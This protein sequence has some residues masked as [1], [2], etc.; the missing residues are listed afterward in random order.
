MEKTFVGRQPI[1]RDGVQVFAYEL[2][3]RTNE[4]NEAAL[5]KADKATGESLV[6]EFMD[7]GLQQIAGQHPAFLNVTRDFVLSEFSSS[8]L[9][10]STVLQIA[11]DTPP[12]ADYVNALARLSGDGYS[13]ALKD[14]VYQ[15]DVRPL[16]EVADIVKLNVQAF[17]RV[18]LARQINALRPHKVKLLAEGVETHSD[19]QH[20]RE[21][22]F[23]Y[24]EGYFFCKPQHASFEDRPLPFNRMSMLQ[25]L[26][27]LQDPDVSFAELELAISRDVAMSYRILR[28]LNSP[29]NALPRKVESLRHAISLVGTNL[30]RQWASVI[31][32]ES[33]ED[34][35]R[36]L[37]IMAMIRA[38]MC[39]QL[40]AAMGCRNTE[41]FFTVG[42]LSLLDALLDRPMAVV[43]NDLP[44]AESIE[45]ALLRRNGVMGDALNC[46]QAYERCNWPKTTCGGLD[47]RKIR[48]TYLTS[49]AWSRS[50]LHELVH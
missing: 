46:V 4:L 11:G 21:L 13:I 23:D 16:A 7:V 14:F 48:E 19:Y 2:F 29:L 50:V 38:H 26:S 47:E 20:C 34:K 28:Y 15:D 18:M 10:S 32:L 33:I 27:K 3:S 5:A 43:L 41:Q 8:V 44:L 42:V 9:K 45:D 49:V 24:F 30:I 12:D 22:G 6:D 25:L 35:P 31:W 17:D 36:E 40:G 37:M 39:Q 1:Y